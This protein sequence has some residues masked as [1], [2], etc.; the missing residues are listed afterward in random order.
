[1]LC[2]EK[3]MAR[4]QISGFAAVLL[5]TTLLASALLNSAGKAQAA[6]ASGYSFVGGTTDE[7]ATV[8]AALAASS[9]DWSLIPGR[10]TIHVTPGSRSRATKGQIWLGSRLLAHGRAA[11]GIVQHEY[12][13]QVDFFLFDAATRA[14]LARALGAKVWW[15][16]HGGLEHDQLGCERFASTLASSYWPSR[17]NSLIRHARGE[18]TAMAPAQFRRLVDEV[19]AAR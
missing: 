11:W 5:A 9:F 19:V 18:A 17:S 6:P 1:L 14:S 13:H 8:R 4:K 2:D 12:A 7:H 16:G 3:S 15:G 10:I